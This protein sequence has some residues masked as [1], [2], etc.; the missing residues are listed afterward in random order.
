MTAAIKERR[1]Q[2]ADFNK[3]AV[4][5]PPLLGLPQEAGRSEQDARAPVCFASA[6]DRITDITL[7]PA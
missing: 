6:I 1:L 4:W 7:S 5:R 3:T 2:A